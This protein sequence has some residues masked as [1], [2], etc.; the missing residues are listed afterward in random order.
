MK[1]HSQNEDAAQNADLNRVFEGIRWLG[2]RGI[3]AAIRAAST[4]PGVYA[5]GTRESLLGLPMEFR[6]I[7]VGRSR[8]LPRRLNEHRHD[9]EANP[10]LRR[11]LLE[12][13]NR[14]EI[15]LAAVDQAYTARVEEGLIRQLKPDANRFLYLN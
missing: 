3:E 4:G 7:Y 10:R 12:N 8:N 11:W 2:T 5:I 9:I 1:T 13:A 14:V 6:W 15:W